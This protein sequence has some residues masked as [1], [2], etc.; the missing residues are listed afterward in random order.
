M[1]RFKKVML[2]HSDEIEP[3][4]NFCVQ[5]EAN[6]FDNIKMELDG[7]IN[8]SALLAGRTIAFVDG[9]IT[10]YRIN[11][12]DTPVT[13]GFTHNSSKLFF[14][15]DSLPVVTDKV[16]TQI[17]FT[18]D[19]IFNDASELSIGGTYSAFEFPGQMS[20]EFNNC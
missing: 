16:L 11:T 6:N 19:I 14:G 18:A 9:G 7:N 20:S 8:L 5:F 13:L 10:S 4:L 2:Q 3:T 15:D 17:T 12:V 1:W